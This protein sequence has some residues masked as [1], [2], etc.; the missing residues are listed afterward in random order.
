MLNNVERL[1][2]RGLVRN[3]KFW[4]VLFW[5]RGG[6]R[7]LVLRG[8]SLAGPGNAARRP[9]CGPGMA[10]D[11]RG[12]IIDFQQFFQFLMPLIFWLVLWAT[13]QVDSHGKDWQHPW[14][15]EKMGV[16]FFGG[17]RPNS[18]HFRGHLRPGSEKI[19][20]PPWS[21]LLGVG[22]FW[23]SGN[24]AVPQIDDHSMPVEMAPLVFGTDFFKPLCGTKYARS[25]LNFQPQ[26]AFLA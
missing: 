15:M 14:L 21:Q 7:R 11:W 10:T 23:H 24:T 4:N 5:N 22:A 17:F 16:N 3:R 25:L 1:L 8:F 2:N 6:I 18:G 19:K 12:G 26:P 9:F 20:P 13:K